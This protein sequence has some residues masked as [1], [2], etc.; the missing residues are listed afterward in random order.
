MF[1]GKKVL[2]CGMAKS[3]QAAALLLRQLGAF[4]TASDSKTEIL[5]DYD[6][7]THGIKCRMG[8]NPDNFVSEFELVIISPGISVYAPFVIKAESLGIPVWGEAELAFRLCPCPMIAITGT[9]GKTTVTTLVGEIVKRHNP[10]TVI[11]GNIGIPLTGLVSKLSPKNIVV[12]EISSFQLETVAAFRPAISTVLN[13]TEDH[14]DRH[15]TMENY[16]A[17]KARIFENQ[18]QNDITVLNYD[19]LITRAMKPPGRVVYFSMYDIPE[20]GVFLRNG[21]IYHR[22]GIITG[23]VRNDKP[24]SWAADHGELLFA[25]EEVPV[26][27]LSDTKVMPENALAAAALSLCAGVSVQQIADVLRSFKGVPHR[28]EYIGTVG[29]ADYY[30]DSKATNVDAAIKGLESF[31]HPVVLIGGGYDKNTDFTPWVKL[32]NE[33]VTHL[34][35]LGQTAQ[36]IINVCDAVGFSSYEKVDSLQDAVFRAG[37]LAIS[38]Q[39]VVLSPSCASFDMFKNF[40]ERGDLFKTYVN[41]LQKGVLNGQP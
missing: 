24:L 2:V 37:K 25:S 9:N 28:L 17:A 23:Q 31:N 5:W 1:D 21:V 15:G 19:N 30:N 16:I 11:A 39:A 36:Q 26:I 10:D 3:G 41:D 6:P 13:M 27:A 34:I 29:G 4:V 22:M 20:A 38:G 14:L 33:K 18:G 35:L 32:F 8:Q 12:A 40:E 7:V